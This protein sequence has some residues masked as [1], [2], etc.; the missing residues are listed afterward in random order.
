[1]DAVQSSAIKLPDCAKDIFAF[2]KILQMQ[3]I[4]MAGIHSAE[5]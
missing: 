2:E 3:D 1:M 4:L 5:E